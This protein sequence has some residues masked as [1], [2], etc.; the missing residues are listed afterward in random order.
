MPCELSLLGR[1]R[2]RSAIW[3]LTREAICRAPGFARRAVGRR[4]GDPAAPAA[5]RCE[6]CASSL[7][8]RRT[9]HRARGFHAA[10]EGRADVRQ[11]AVGCQIRASAQMTRRGRSRCLL[12]AGIPPPSVHCEGDG[13]VRS[14][15]RLDSCGRLRGLRSAGC[16]SLAAAQ[17]SEARVR[18]GAHRLPAGRAAGRRSTRRSYL[19]LA[20][21][22]LGRLERRGADV[23]RGVFR[24]VALRRPESMLFAGIALARN[25]LW[26]ERHADARAILESVAPAGDVESLRA[27]L[28]SGGRLRVAADAFTEAWQALE[29]AR[30]LTCGVSPAIESIVRVRS[31]RSGAARR[32]RG[33]A[34]SCRGRP[35]G[36]A[37]RASAVADDQ[38]EARATSR[39]SSAAE[40]WAHARAAAKHLEHIRERRHPAAFEIA[41]RDLC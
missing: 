20:Q 12:R 3:P 30:P 21:T 29:R 14:A 33:A 38:A 39:A 16:C 40:R 22:D 13:S 35:G 25:L 5:E 41:H 31:H 2:C 26:Q 19:G 28:V 9:R 34:D 36:R 11:R 17:P 37:C 32:S 24:G 1:Q 27:I 18:R 4:A 8:R 7:R 23:P 6:T 10:A 15:R